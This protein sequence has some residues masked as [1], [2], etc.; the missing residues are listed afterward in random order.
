MN[1]LVRVLLIIIAILIV[2][3]VIAGAAAAVTARR[4]FPTTDGRVTVPGLREEVN[5]YWDEYGIPHIY[6]NN[7]DDLFFAQGYVHAQD[8]FWQMEFWRHIGQ[9]RL[10]EIVGEATVESDMFIRTFG[11]NRIAADMLAYYEAETLEVMAILDAYS[12]GVNAYVDTHRNELSLNYT[13]LGLVNEPWEIEP[14]TPINTLSWAVVMSDNLSGNWSE[15]I[16]RT[17]LVK[18]LGESTVANL[19]PLYPFDKRPVIAPTADLVNDLPQAL[20]PG[21]ATTAIE[22]HR[23]NTR[24]RTQPALTQALGSGPFL[25]S[26]NWV[27]AGEHTATGLPL[28]ANDPHLGI[29]MPA[30]W[31]EVGLHAPGWDMRGFSFAGV[32][33]IIIGHNDRIAWGVTNVGADV[34]DLYIEKINPSNPNQYEYQGQWEDMEV[35][36]EVIRVNGGEDVTLNVRVTRHGPIINDMV[37]DLTD[38]LAFKWTAQEPSRIMQS[39]LLLNQAQNYDDFREALRYWDIPSLN[40]VYA[41]VDGNIAYQMPGLVPVRPTSNGLLPVPGWT[42]EHEWEGWIPYE[43]LPAMFNPDEGYI[44][45]ANNA[46]VDEDYPHLI[47]L[48]WAD[49]DRAERIRQILQAAIVG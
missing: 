29:Q 35:I 42:G 8:R 17:N 33:G 7:Q 45:T 26:N 20:R 24:V 16:D 25:G 31:Y 34:Q 11:W 10:S 40:V 41:D 30:I 43:E 19:L 4:P 48:Y 12:A 2:L 28:L 1:R 47:S 3:L 32:P 9:G 37:D 15:E 13:I 18:T 46:V 21:G 14:W 36:Q 23:V 49:G 39:V 38:P 5:I 27:V 44:V 22:W 6:A